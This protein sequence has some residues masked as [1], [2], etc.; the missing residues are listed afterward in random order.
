[1]GHIPLLCPLF[2][3]RHDAAGVERARQ[4]AAEAIVVTSAEALRAL[5][6][7]G[8]LAS[9]PVFAVGTTT[10]DV[11]RSIGFEQVGAADGDASA[12]VALLT[13][14]LAT[15]S[16]TRLLY[17]AGEPRM[18]TLEQ[19]LA[20]ARFALE[21]VVCYR[22]Q[23][24]DFAGKTVDEVFAARPDAVLLYSGAAARRFFELAEVQV[25]QQPA[26]R[27][28]CLSAAI[29]ADIP[30]EFADRT[31]FALFPREGDLLALL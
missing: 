3:P 5:G 7:A 2:E 23:P 30:P 4:A 9:R 28:L 14:R 19:E 20:A 15:S 8:N 21:A 11:A 24:V 13:T 22:M 18:S 12:L 31:A 29:A 6:R 16:Q 10:A 26:L 27:L 1:M 17:L 25:R